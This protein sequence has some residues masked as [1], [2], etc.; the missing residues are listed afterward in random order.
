MKNRTATQSTIFLLLSNKDKLALR[1]VSKDNKQL[2]VD[3]QDGP[4]TSKCDFIIGIDG[5]FY[6]SKYLDSA[7]HVYNTTI[8]STS[9]KPAM[10]YKLA[11]KEYIINSGLGDL[12]AE[13]EDLPATGRNYSPLNNKHAW[14]VNQVWVLAQIHKGRSFELLSLLTPQYIKRQFQ[15]NVYSAFAKEVATAIKANY[16]ISIASICKVQLQP[17]DPIQAKQL[18]ASDLNLTDSEIQRA[19]DS[20]NQAIVRHYKQ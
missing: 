13:G 9:N 16:Q 12:F 3:Y 20:V 7:W 5:M 2:L 18:L 11:D 6:H 17:S 8:Q 4:Y 10:L 19:V 15:P 1:Q 14:D